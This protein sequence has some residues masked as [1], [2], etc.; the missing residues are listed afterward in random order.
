[1]KNSFLPAAVIAVAAAFSCTAASVVT[2]QVVDALD[3]PC[4]IDTLKPLV[5]PE[6]ALA[7]GEY[8][9]VA[10]LASAGESLDGVSL[11]LKG[12]PRGVE[13]ETRLA[14]PYRRMLRGGKAS[15]VGVGARSDPALWR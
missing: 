5:Q 9:S 14:A 11:R 2:L 10:L 7:V 4:D 3:L 13:V 12:L 1:M 15:D 8:E 6:A